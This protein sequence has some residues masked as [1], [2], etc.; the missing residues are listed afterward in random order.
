M[1]QHDEPCE[2]RNNP[3]Y[4]IFMLIKESKKK[5]FLAQSIIED[6]VTH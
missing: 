3:D 6:D 2:S 4:I 1:D 5:S